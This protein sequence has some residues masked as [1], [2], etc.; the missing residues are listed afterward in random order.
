[1][2]ER[3]ELSFEGEGRQGPRTWVHVGLTKRNR[4]R[5]HLGRARRA[6][7]RGD[8]GAWAEARASWAVEEGRAGGPRGRCWA[9]GRIKGEAQGAGLRARARLG[10]GKRRVL[11][12]GGSRAEV[13]WENGWT[14]GLARW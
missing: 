2:G 6:A 3:R 7:G 12:L 14:A 1:V 5:W 4:A 8:V 11:G 10:R 9:I 13:R